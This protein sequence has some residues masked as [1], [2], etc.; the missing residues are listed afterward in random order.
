VRL[1][2][3]FYHTGTVTAQGKPCDTKTAITEWANLIQSGVI[4]V[5]VEPVPVSQNRISKHLVLAENFDKIREV[6]HGLPGEISEKDVTGPA[7]VYRIENRHD[8]NRVTISQYN[9]GMLMVQGLSSTLFES[10]C[11]VLDRHL[12][13]SLADRASRFLPRESERNTVTAYLEQPNSENESTQ[14]L[15]QNIDKKVLNFLYDNDQRTLLAAAGV[16]NAFQK[17]NGGLPDYSVV[18]MPFA[19]A[20][21]GF[22]V[23]LAIHLELTSEDALATKADES[24]VGTW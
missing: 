18:V 24:I 17:S 2:V 11:E 22:L 20:F 4:A 13:Q 8:G 19:K 7:D 5:S 9:S 6:I 21:E 3:N 14:W 10:V 1:P 23:K 12:T 15:F 16:R